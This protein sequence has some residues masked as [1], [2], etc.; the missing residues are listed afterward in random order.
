[1]KRMIMGAAIGA[2][3]MYLLDPEHGSQRRAHLTGAWR[4]QKGTVLEAARSTAGTVSSVS[5]GMG[6]MVG[7]KVSEI[8]NPEPAR[9][10]VSL[11][12]GNGKSDAAVTPEDSARSK[13]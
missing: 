7:E 9:K 2:A 4:A 10:T 3:A 5:Q 11:A 1:M 6:A 8:R 12:S 13:S